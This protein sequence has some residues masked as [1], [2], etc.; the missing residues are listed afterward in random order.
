M[1]KSMRNGDR[2][3]IRQRERKGGDGD[4]IAKTDGKSVKTKHSL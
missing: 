3:C 1:E 4:T 2:W